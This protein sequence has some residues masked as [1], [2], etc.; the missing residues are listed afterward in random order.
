MSG[1]LALQV[2]SHYGIV[3]E[4]IWLGNCIKNLEGIIKI[5]IFGDSTELDESAHGIVI[6]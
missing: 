5:A 2:T 1:E 3:N 4:C 6:G